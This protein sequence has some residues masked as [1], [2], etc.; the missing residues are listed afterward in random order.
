MLEPELKQH[1]SVIIVSYNTC[2]L[3]QQC[4]KSL[5]TEVQ[6]LQAEII[7]I[8]NES[9][10][11][12]VAMIQAEFPTVRLL[13]P[14]HNLG[15]GAANNRAAALSTA[16]YLLLLN[17]DTLVL[18]GALSAL[19]EF[20]EAHPAAAIISPK[21]LNADG[22][23]QK[24]CWRFPTLWR[25]FA[26]SIGLLHLIRKPS[27]YLTTQYNRPMRVD[28]AIGA[29]LLV[30][31][32]LFQAIGGFDEQFFMYAEETDLC[33]R[34]LLQGHHTYYCPASRII[35]LGGGSNQTTPAMRL[36]QFYTSQEL[37]F[38]KYYGSGGLRLFKLISIFRCSL[39]F[40]LWK[41]VLL[42]QPKVKPTIQVRAAI[43]S[44]SLRWYLGLTK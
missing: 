20:A 1:I 24:N 37:Y 40:L 5:Q 26:E 44:W 13:S 18:P 3:T 30:R 10:D 9:T 14:G 34:L 25:A 15:F 8:D 22:S 2:K 23:L 17:S 38:R 21:L 16:K 4:L 12:T 33:R 39:R 29:C 28:F 32:D 27:N 11:G 31:R 19:V 43:N 7:V 6:S 36:K 42:I 41:T 35:H